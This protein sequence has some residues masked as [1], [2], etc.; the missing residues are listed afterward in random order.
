MHYCNYR[1]HGTSRKEREEGCPAYHKTNTSCMK[2][3]HF[4]AAR[5]LKVRAY[6]TSNEDPNNKKDDPTARL[7]SK[8]QANRGR[9]TQQKL[10]KADDSS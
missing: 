1:R 5:H 3:G 6:V 10:L 4:R 7:A 8:R 2:Q 9:G